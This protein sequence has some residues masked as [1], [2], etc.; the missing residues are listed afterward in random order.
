MTVVGQEINEDVKA[1]FELIGLTMVNQ[2]NTGMLGNLKTLTYTFEIEPEKVI[3]MRRN[4]MNELSKYSLRLMPMY[5]HG[6]W[7]RIFVF[8]TIRV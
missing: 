5:V 1:V 8:K 2:V 6:D 3:D 4:L 7:M